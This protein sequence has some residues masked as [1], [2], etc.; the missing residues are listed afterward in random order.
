M[1]TKP[2][3]KRANQ[4]E[5]YVEIIEQPQGRGLRFRYECEGRTAGSIVGETSSIEK[6]TFPTIKVWSHLKFEAVVVV[7]FL[8]FIFKTYKI[9]I[10]TINFII[11]T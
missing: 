8:Y 9:W 7:N 6:K 5:P 3:A 11:K 1:A 10:E 2:A 4:N